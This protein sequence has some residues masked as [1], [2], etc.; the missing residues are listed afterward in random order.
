MVIDS[1]KATVQEQ[2]ASRLAQAGYDA[3]FLKDLWRLLQDPRFAGQIA[4]NV[5]DTMSEGAAAAGQLL[6]Y[7]QQRLPLPQ[8]PPA[9]RGLVSA[10]SQQLGYG[11][12]FN[13]DDEL[14]ARPPEEHFLDGL[15]AFIAALEFFRAPGRIN[16]MITVDADLDELR[17]L[18]TK[19]D[20][21]RHLLRISMRFTQTVLANLSVME[22]RAF[23]LMKTGY[24]RVRTAAETDPEMFDLLEDTETCLYGAAQKAAER[25]KENVSRDARVAA[26]Y[27][28]KLK[29]AGQGSAD[30]GGKD[31]NVVSGELSAFFNAVRRLMAPQAPA[32]PDDRSAPR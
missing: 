6:S 8:V 32:S 10:L 7:F 2:L 14:D 13:R 15:Q 26:E 28:K 29:L 20:L 21:S 9:Y 19:I 27:E 25:R 31:G 30:G 16:K 3:P 24:D 18:Y 4:F 1:D 23:R 22:N 12:Y 17:G 5:G 11:S